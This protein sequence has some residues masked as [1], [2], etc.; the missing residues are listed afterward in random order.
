MRLGNRVSAAGCR[1]DREGTA[2][3]VVQIRAELGRPM[4]HW[5]ERTLFDK[6]QVLPVSFND[7]SVWIM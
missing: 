7:S 2:G 1:L 3:S 4:H 6:F 5:D